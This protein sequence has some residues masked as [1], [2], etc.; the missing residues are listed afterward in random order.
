MNQSTVY[1]ANWVYP[2]K[3]PEW[4]KQIIDEFSHPPCKCESIGCTWV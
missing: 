2:E 1:E 3:N 4:Q